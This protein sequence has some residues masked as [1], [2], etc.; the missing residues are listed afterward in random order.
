M[1]NCTREGRACG[2][3]GRPYDWDGTQLVPRGEYAD[4]NDVLDNEYGIGG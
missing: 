1:L 3:A 2:A 4:Y